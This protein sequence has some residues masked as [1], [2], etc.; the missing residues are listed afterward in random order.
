[1][2]PVF[3][4]SDSKIEEGRAVQGGCQ[5]G[6]WTMERVLD[7]S[8]GLSLQMSKKHLASVH[9]M[10]PTT[11]R[12]KYNEKGEFGFKKNTCR[13]LFVCFVLFCF[14]LAVTIF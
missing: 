1:V 7:K 2:S 10:L 6:I 13:F 3:L 11:R 9:L 5:W 14:V 8:T 12:R 4:R